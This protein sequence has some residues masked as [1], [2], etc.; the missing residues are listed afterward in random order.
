MEQPSGF[1]LSI[2]TSS[3]VC[4]LNR[5]YM[6]S[7][8]HHVLGLSDY[9]NF[10]PLLVSIFIM[11]KADNSLFLIFTSKSTMFIWYMWMISSSQ[12]A[13]ALKFKH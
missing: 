3:L 2:A 1:N 4:K 6:T 9:S 12:E 13:L 8:K 11:S 5:A 10:S 7:N